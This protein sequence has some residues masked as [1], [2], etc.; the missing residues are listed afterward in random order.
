M[1][2]KRDEKE[3]N[4]WIFGA[5]RMAADGTFRAVVFLDIVTLSFFYDPIQTGRYLSVKAGQTV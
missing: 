1:A 4:S 5:D 3:M 2:T